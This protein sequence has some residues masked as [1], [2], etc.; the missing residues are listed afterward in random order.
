MKKEIV[1]NY[2]HLYKEDSEGPISAYKFLGWR[3]PRE[4]QKCDIIEEQRRDTICLKST[5]MDVYPA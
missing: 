4:T 2:I 1:G 3:K 5:F